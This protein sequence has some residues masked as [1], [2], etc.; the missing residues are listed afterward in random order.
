MPGC[1]NRR[2]A[3]LSRPELY[4]TYKGSKRN[5]HVAAPYRLVLGVINHHLDTLFGEPVSVR[6][7]I[8]GK[9]R[10]SKPG[11]RMQHCWDVQ[12]SEAFEDLMHKDSANPAKRPMLCPPLSY[13]LK[14]GVAVRGALFVN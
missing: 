4:G 1:P 13:T 7:A 10:G 3:D 12:G 9:K 11:E 2:T 5:A 14:H 6:F 8:P